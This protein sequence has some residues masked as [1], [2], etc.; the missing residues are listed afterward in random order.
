VCG[1]TEHKRQ[2]GLIFTQK[3]EAK[4]LKSAQKMYMGP[5]DRHFVTSLRTD[6][7]QGGMGLPESSELRH[8]GE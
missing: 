2:E 7:T 5:T 1:V 3:E 8:A 4:K 6:V